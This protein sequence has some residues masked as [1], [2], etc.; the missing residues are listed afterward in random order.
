MEQNIADAQRDCIAVVL[1]GIHPDAMTLQIARIFATLETRVNAL[2][3]PLPICRTCGEYDP[4]A[5][6]NRDV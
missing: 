3:P 4:L 6:R 1:S 2:R 5:S